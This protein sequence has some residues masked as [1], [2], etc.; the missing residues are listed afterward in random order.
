[1]SHV[2]SYFRSH[3]ANYRILSGTSPDVGGVSFFYAPDSSGA[4]MT[5]TLTAGWSDYVWLN[6]RLIARIYNGQLEAVH[7]DQV[8]RP[9]VVTSASKTVVWRARNFAFDRTVTVAN[10]VPLNLGFPGQYY[11]AESVNWNNGF[12]TTTRAGTVF[13]E[14][15]DRAIRWNKYICMLG[16]SYYGC[17][18]KWLYLLQ[19]RLL[20]ELHRRKQV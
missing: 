4:L 16:E 10:T 2:F 15:S 13:G 18:S 6:G 11:D 14:R 9:E 12:R 3:R 19:F 1:M 5:E 7:D 17:R 8:G 20:C